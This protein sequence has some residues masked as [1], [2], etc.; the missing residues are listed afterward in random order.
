MKHIA[1]IMPMKGREELTRRTF[2]YYETL[3]LE[4][5]G[6]MT[7]HLWPVVD[8]HYDHEYFEQYFISPL[9]CPLGAK[10]NSGIQACVGNYDG[11]MILG[12]DDL[13]APAVF[14]SIATWNPYYQ[15]IKGVHFFDSTSGEMV[16]AR[17]SHCGA[18]KYFSKA[19]LD[20]CDWQPYDNDAV[21]NV[22][23]GPNRFLRG[24]QHDKLVALIDKPLCIDV[25]T[26]ENMTLWEDV[27]KYNAT[28]Q[29]TAVETAVC[30]DRMNGE[31]PQRFMG[32]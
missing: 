25:K 26:S 5:K 11:V 28:H 30:F 24:V 21:N 20:G 16:F 10:F 23:N 9:D 29:L 32:L 19:F 14:E 22:D 4:R 12:S 17:K 6:I 8:N 27:S 18:G 1:I 3:D 2:L 13:I 15:E 7:T 31:W